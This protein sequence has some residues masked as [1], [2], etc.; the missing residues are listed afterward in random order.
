MINLNDLTV[1]DLKDIEELQK[2]RKESQRLYNIVVNNQKVP[3]I[4]DD[5]NRFKLWDDTNNAEYLT[6]IDGE[7]VWQARYLHQK[8]DVPINVEKIYK[9]MVYAYEMEKDI[10]KRGLANGNKEAIS[11]F[12]AY[13]NKLTDK[14]QNEGFNKNKKSNY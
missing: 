11:Y 3:L 8:Y 10:T 13:V 14:Q 6:L 5:K 1:E 7:W 2:F 12:T 9:T 4:L